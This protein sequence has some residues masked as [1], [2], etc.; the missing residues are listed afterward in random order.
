VNE[1][2]RRKKIGELLMPGG[3]PVGDPGRRPGVRLL[4]G[5]PEEAREFLRRFDQ[6]GQPERV[7]GYDGTLIN[8][9]GK[10]RVGLRE[11][12]RSG[13][14]TVDVQVQWLPERLRKIKF[15]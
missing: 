10:D 1:A 15:V 7:E 5:G 6:L 4:P 13:E 2:E 3:R 11:R 8:L 14:P 9:G 12:S